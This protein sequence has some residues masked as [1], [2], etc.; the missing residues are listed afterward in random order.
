MLPVNKNPNLYLCT[1]DLEEYFFESHLT[2]VL[3]FFCLLVFMSYLCSC[4]NRNKLNSSNNIFGIK[5]FFLLFFTLISTPGILYS[6]CHF[7]CFRCLRTPIFCV[8]CAV[9]VVFLT[10]VAQRY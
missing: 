8:F 6:Y 5:L 2:Y 9:S 4:N 3:L 1:T 10:I 7:V